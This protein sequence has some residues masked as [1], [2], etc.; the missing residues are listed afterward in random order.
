MNFR[1]WNTE[2]GEQNMEYEIW[3]MGFGI[4]KIEYGIRNTNMEYGI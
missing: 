2:Y 1:I 3:K 4:R